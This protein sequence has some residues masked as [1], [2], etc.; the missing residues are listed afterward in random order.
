MDTMYDNSV[1]VTF[2][3]TL[4]NVEDTKNL[5]VPVMIT[6]PIPASINPNF[7]VV[8]HYGQDGSVH[9]RILP[10]IFRE[11]AQWY[12]SFTLTS[13][14]DFIMTQVE[15]NRPLMDMYRMYDPNSGEHFYT[16]S[17]EEKNN[18]IAAGWNYEGIGF[19]FPLTTG[20]PVYRLYDPVTGEH[21]YTMDVAEV[22]ELMAAGWNKEGIAFNSAF[23]N[24]VP[25]YRL[26]NP[27]ATR[28]AYH[29]TASV[30]EKNNLIA[31]G[32]EYQG[33]A[34]YSMGA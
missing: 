10:H 25:Q 17:D 29:F 1:S 22:N 24:E 32:W 23:E 4:D 8:L 3:M 19:T 12:A 18:L 20:D 5:A 21:L 30:E 7:L 15:V 6:L 2:S 16:G 33:I 28:G 11:G 9:E 27:N 13:F 34:W 14:S 26:H 31:A